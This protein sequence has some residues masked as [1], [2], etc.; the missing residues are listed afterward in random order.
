MKGTEV[1]NPRRGVPQWGYDADTQTCTCQRI[2]GSRTLPTFAHTYERCMIYLSVNSTTI[3]TAPTSLSSATIFARTKAKPGTTDKPSL[4]VSCLFKVCS[5]VS[6]A[7]AFVFLHC[8]VLHCIARLRFTDGKAW[9]HPQ[10]A[11]LTLTAVLHC[12][13]TLSI[14]NRDQQ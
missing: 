3:G 12:G 1:L 6:E 14:E 13:H 2:C 11:R 7:L 8:T 5:G 9:P 4:S 10:T